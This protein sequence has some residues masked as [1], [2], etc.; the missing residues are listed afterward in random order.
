L[1]SA[2]LKHSSL[3]SET[4]FTGEVNPILVMAQTVPTTC[5]TDED[6]AWAQKQA[7]KWSPVI[8]SIIAMS[9]KSTAV[10]GRN[11]TQAYMITLAEAT[12][13]GGSFV[14]KVPNQKKA[15]T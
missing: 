9:I 10:T 6:F 4:F 11:S 7:M 1:A 12:G 2:K 13:A 14:H 8:L 5:K 15:M 3:A